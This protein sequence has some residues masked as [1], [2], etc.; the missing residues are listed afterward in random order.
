MCCSFQISVAGQR[1]PPWDLWATNCSWGNLLCFLPA[2]LS[3]LPL[4]LLLA[5]QQFRHISFPQG[6]TPACFFWGISAQGPGSQLDE[7]G[8]LGGLLLRVRGRED[9]GNGYVHDALAQLCIKL[10]EKGLEIYYWGCT[11]KYR[12]ENESFFFLNQDCLVARS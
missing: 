12:W 6:R 8:R 5:W 2:R 1:A 3:E 7:G 9:A 11:S 10:P 4:F